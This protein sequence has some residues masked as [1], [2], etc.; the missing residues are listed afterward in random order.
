M[1]SLFKLATH[2]K[3]V[4]QADFCLYLQIPARVYGRSVRSDNQLVSIITNVKYIVRDRRLINVDE[5]KDFTEVF[6]KKEKTPNI[7]TSH[8]MSSNEKY[9]KYSF[10]LIYCYLTSV[11]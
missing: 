9:F 4:P 11:P 7:S 3:S 8:V 2:K 5:D 10:T 1:D 6:L